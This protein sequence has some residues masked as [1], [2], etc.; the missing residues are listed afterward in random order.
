M[1]VVGFPALIIGPKGV[2]PALTVL[3]QF[4]TNVLKLLY[5]HVLSL[6]FHH[7]PTA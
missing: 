6:L 3:L 7:G 4:I 1:S 5:L 2:F